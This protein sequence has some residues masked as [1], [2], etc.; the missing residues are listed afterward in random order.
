[1]KLKKGDRVYECRGKQAV[2]I[3]IMTKPKC[4]VQNDGDFYWHWKARIVETGEVIEYGISEDA[5][6]YGPHLYRTNPNNHE[7]N[8]AELL[9]PP[10][11]R[12]GLIK[13]IYSMMKKYAMFK[14]I[15]LFILTCLPLVMGVAQDL[16]VY[17]AK[18]PVKQ[19]EWLDQSEHPYPIPYFKGKQMFNRSGRDINFNKRYYAKRDRRGRMKSEGMDPTD[20]FEWHY[21]KKGRMIWMYYLERRDYGFFESFIYPFYQANG[22]VGKYRICYSAEKDSDFTELI[23]EVLER[24]KYRNWTRRRFLD[25]KKKTVC[26]QERTIEYYK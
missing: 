25:D 17:E 9:L 20:A 8:N 19:I 23:V 26:T 14:R 2:M 24:D 1:M 22:E 3:E 5:P 10:Y 12:H 4:T 11:G 16:A 13:R 15:I 7:Y 6:G 18:G 21:D